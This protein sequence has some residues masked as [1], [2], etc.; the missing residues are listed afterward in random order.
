MEK[1]ERECLENARFAQ[2]NAG[3]SVINVREWLIAPK[4]V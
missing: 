2:R 4:N 3:R 1:S